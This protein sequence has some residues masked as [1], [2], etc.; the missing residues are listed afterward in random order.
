MTDWSN[1]PEAG[2]IAENSFVEDG[3]VVMNTLQR[4]FVL[5][6]EKGHFYWKQVGIS[7]N[8]L[9]ALVFLEFLFDQ[10]SENSPIS[11][12]ELLAP[13]ILGIETQR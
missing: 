3:F 5:V 2:I 8:E 10:E 1:S 6:K 7:R 11:T 4:S 12:N 9:L 13:L